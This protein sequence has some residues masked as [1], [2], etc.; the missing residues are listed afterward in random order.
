MMV[1]SLGI[2]MLAFI[3]KIISFCKSKARQKLKFPYSSDSF[4]FVEK[5]ETKTV[6]HLNEGVDFKVL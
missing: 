1:F 6:K 3:E 2:D 5:K 4:S